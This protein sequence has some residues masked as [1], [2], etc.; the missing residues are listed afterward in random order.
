MS[1]IRMIVSK[2]F[3]QADATTKST[4]LSQYYEVG[5]TKASYFFYQIRMPILSI[6]HDGIDR[7]VDTCIYK[8]VVWIKVT[9]FSL[10]TIG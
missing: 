3:K 6:R 7:T 8:E 4:E 9:W 5:R 1:V 10:Q 2:N